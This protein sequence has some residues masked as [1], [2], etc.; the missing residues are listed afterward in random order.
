MAIESVSSAT[1]ASQLV[2]STQSR[3]AEQTQQAEQA[4]QADQTRQANAPR[5]TERPKPENEAAENRPQQPVVN[6]QGQMTGKVI[7]TVA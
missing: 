6:A 1:Y 4:R 7:N 5:E 2:T 3:Q